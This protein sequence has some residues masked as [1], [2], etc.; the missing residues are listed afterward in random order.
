[1]F[2]DRV[3]Q[4][5]RDAG[6]WIR[7]SELTA[8]MRPNMQRGIQLDEALKQ[9]TREGRIKVDYRSGARGPSVKGYKIIDEE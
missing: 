4:L 5:I 9:L 7:D 8:K 2:C 1:V 6:G 3:Y